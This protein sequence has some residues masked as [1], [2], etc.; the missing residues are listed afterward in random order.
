MTERENQDRPVKLARP[1]MGRAEAD[2]VSGVLGSGRLVCGPV[3]QE[4]ERAVSGR[5]GIRH[6]VAMSSGTAALWAAL[7]CL[8]LRPGD[9]VIV[10]A[11]TFPAT[12]A[13]VIFNGATPVFADVSHGTFDIDPG[14]LPRRF[15]P[16]TRLVVAVDQFGLPADYP[17]IE[18]ELARH[19]GARL[20][21]DSACALGSVLDNKPCGTFGEASVLSFHPRKIITT[22]EGGM[23]LTD[24]AGLADALRRLRSHGVDGAGA[25]VEPG[26]NLR[27]AETAGAMGLAQLGR[28]DAF[29][30]RRTE[31]ASVYRAHLPA[32]VTMQSVPPTARPNWQTLAVLLA[33]G[34]TAGGRDRVIS[35][36]A[37][38][39]IE[40]TVASYCLAALPAYAPYAPALGELGE[41]MA[42]H[43]RGLALPMHT[44][45]TDGDVRRVCAALG[46]LA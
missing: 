14:E 35:G 33:E 32:G 39:G 43:E 10:P 37:R 30:E 18:R 44:L 16:R 15:T 2:A 11:L 24:H 21:T 41:A 38:R 46:E 8:D 23:V 1:D 6:A 17:A 25:Y 19:P 4:F 29:I 3:V 28:L 13:A 40:A 45:L 7:R 12:A 9:E 27:M 34:T 31:L 20:V 5:L 42:V 36:L 26:L 22:G